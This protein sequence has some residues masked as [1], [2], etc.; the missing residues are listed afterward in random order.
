MYVVVQHGFALY[1][2]LADPWS[3][4]LAATAQVDHKSAQS[5]HSAGVVLRLPFAVTSDN[6]LLHL[7]LIQFIRQ[8][9]GTQFCLHNSGQLS[10]RDVTSSH[11]PESVQWPSADG[12]VV[13]A[14]AISPS[15]AGRIRGPGH[16][17][18]GQHSTATAIQ[19]ARAASNAA[20]QSLAATAAIT[21]QALPR[22]GS[23]S[24]LADLRQAER[25]WMQVAQAQPT[26]AATPPAKVAELKRSSRQAARAV[27]QSQLASEAQELLQSAP[28]A[29]ATVMLH[30][31]LPPLQWGK[32]VRAHRV[33]GHRQVGRS[34]DHFQGWT[35]S[36]GILKPVASRQAPAAARAL[37]A[38]GRAFRV[39][40][41]LFKS[42]PASNPKAMAPEP[43]LLAA[44]AAKAPEE[45]ASAFIPRHS[46]K[47]VGPQLCYSFLLC[48]QHKE[49]S[50][51]IKCV[52]FSWHQAQTIECTD[53]I[54][55][56]FLLHTICSLC[57]LL[58]AYSLRQVLFLCTAY[59]ATYQPAFN[60]EV[61]CCPLWLCTP[62]LPWRC[63]IPAVLRLICRF[64][65]C[66]GQSSKKCF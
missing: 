51:D 3:S 54:A 9:A 58:H 7:S 42:I 64:F 50:R 13:P 46:R 52:V 62:C 1:C 15:A 33:R 18:S 49:P 17:T 61:C 22:K 27:D 59:Y 2:A 25:K 35:V 5:V 4:C 26:P 34:H 63:S 10:G 20:K 8:P 6:C 60:S 45:I 29:D 32:Q 40:P 12:P 53:A 28:Q 37:Q 14:P 23:S 66:A 43:L 41:S 47:K 19:L 57:L 48:M 56:P 11:L 36:G 38:E 24:L 39:E 65:C 31:G 44:A 30:T 55:L 21:D 16:R